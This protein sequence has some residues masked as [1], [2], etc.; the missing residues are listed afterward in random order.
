VPSTIY[1]Y[2]ERACRRSLE[3]VA[4]EPIIADDGN[5]A[6]FSV[7]IT[8]GRVTAVSYKCT[9]CTT[10]IALCEHLA[11]FVIGLDTDAVLEM[12]PETLLE[13]HPDI[14]QAKRPTSALALRA[15]QSAVQGAN[16]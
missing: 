12:Q 2:F 11:E 9:S 5:C 4:G 3:P 8:A 10:L 13:L 14:P 15:L 6:V 16:D 1:D 7:G